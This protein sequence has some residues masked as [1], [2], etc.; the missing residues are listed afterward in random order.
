MNGNMKM[1]KKCG[2]YFSD[3][4]NFQFFLL[5]L[6]KITIGTLLKYYAF[7]RVKYYNFLSLMSESFIRF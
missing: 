6:E 5:A 4:D 3:V 1:A 7:L 2:I